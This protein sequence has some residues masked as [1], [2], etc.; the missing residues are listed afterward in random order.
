MHAGKGAADDFCQVGIPSGVNITNRYF[1]VGL[2][3]L[4]APTLAHR[5]AAHLDP[6]GVVHQQVEDAV[7]Q[8]WERATARRLVRATNSHRGLEE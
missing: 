4:L 1:V 8:A 3:T 6:M 2:S 7:R 5:I